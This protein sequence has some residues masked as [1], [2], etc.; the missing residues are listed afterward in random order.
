MNTRI[1][2]DLKDP[3]LIQ[4]VQ[5][6]AVSQHKS[7]REVVVDALKSYFSNKKENKAL[8]KLAEKTFEEWDNPKDAEYD[9]L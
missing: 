6:E 4:L 9:K 2:L 5:L 8:L 3:A 7:L 1:T